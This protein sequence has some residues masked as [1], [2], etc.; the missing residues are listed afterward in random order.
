MGCRRDF[1]GGLVSRVVEEILIS[2]VLTEFSVAEY[3]AGHYSA[4]YS[5]K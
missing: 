3:S 2:A 4:K 1:F 5:A